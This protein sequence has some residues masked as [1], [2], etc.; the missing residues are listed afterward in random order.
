MS[1]LSERIARLS[2]EKRAVLEKRLQGSRE[3]APQA[4]VEPIAIVGLACRFPGAEDPDGFWQLLRGRGDAIREVPAD[5]WDAEALY[6]SNPDAPN[7]VT[8]RWGGFLD[9]VAD[10]DAYFFGI[11]PREAARMDPQ[12]RL[13]LEAAWEAFEDAGQTVDQLAGSQTGVF[14]GLHSHSSDYF[15]LQFDPAAGLDAFS[16]PGAA[17]NIAS[18]RLSYFFDLQGPNLVV[19]TACSSSLVAV[20]LACQSLRA[21]ECSMALAAGVNL[22]LTPYWTLP[23]ARMRMLAADGRCKT[24][25]AKADGMVRSEGCGAVV[26]K[27]VSDAVAHGDRIL[28]VI[29]GSAV[30]Q[31]GRTNGITAPNGVS[32]R[33]LLRQA[34]RNAGVRADAIS[35]VE[36][37][38]TGTAL[39]DPIEVEALAEVVGAS[40][41]DGSRC[42]L[43]AAKTNIGH[44]EGAAGIAG[45]IKIVLSLQHDAIPPLVHFS[46]LNPH[47][48]LA[49]TALEIPTALQAWTRG[50]A[51]RLA[52]VSS[53][54]WSGTNAHV[55][56]EEAPA[57]AARTD[58]A[59]V[60]R[61]FVLPLS[62]RHPDALKTLAARYRDLLAASDPA[63]VSLED[64]C[65]TA[66]L[67]RSHHEH[68]VALVA[69]SRRSMADALNAFVAG[70]P[71]RGTSSGRQSPG[72][73]PGVVFV[74][75]GQGPQWYAMGRELLE[76]E[77]VFAE[78]V[79][80][81]DEIVRKIAGWSPRAELLA[82]EA[83]SRVDQTEIA[84]PLLFTLQVAL[85]ALWRSWGVAP[86]AAIGHS[87]GEIA[88]AHLAGALTLEEAARVAVQRGQ[89]MQQ[90][91]G[92]GRMAVVEMPSRD[93]ERA[94]APFA[95]RVWIAAVNSAA[96]TVVSGEPAAIEELT[97]QLKSRE[98]LVR[99]MPVGYAFHSGQMEPC[100]RAVESALDGLRP[101][102]PRIPV[103][104]TVTGA[105]YSGAFDAAYWRRNVR[106]PV[107]FG[108]AL[109]AAIADDS[110]GE[111]KVFL[112][113]GPHP[114]L[115]EAIEHAIDGAPHRVVHSLRR[116]APERAS[117]LAALGGLYAAGCAVNWK[118][119][120]GASARCV[121]LPAYPW[122]RERYWIPSQTS[123]LLN[124][125]PR[126]ADADSGAAANRSP[127]DAL[128]EIGWV[129]APLPSSSDASTV[130]G[131]WLV[132][133]DDTGLGERLASALE[134]RGAT[135]TLVRRPGDVAR[136][137]ARVA[138]AA[139]LR[140]IVHLWS[141]DAAA[142]GI[143]PESVDA[144][145]KRICGSV[146]DLVKAMSAS[147][148][149]A[150]PVWLVTRGAQR[151]A[152]ADLS[153]AVSQAPLWGMARSV[154]IELSDVRFVRVDLDPAGSPADVDALIAELSVGPTADDQ[155]AYRGAIRHGAR[156]MRIQTSGGLGAGLTPAQSD[157]VY[158]ITGGLG[159]LGLHVANRLVARGA[160]RIV[161]AGRSGRAASSSAVDALRAAGADVV[162]A[163]ADVAVR[164]DVERLLQT[165][166]SLG[167]LRGIVHA[168]GV[169]DDGVVVQ[170]EWDRFARVMAPK[171]AGAWNLHA[172]T[173]DLSLDFFV[174]FS[175]A[176][177]V[178]GS[179][180]QANY[181]AAN[182]F[183]DALAHE[184]RRCGLA[185]L[186]VNWGAWAAGGMATNLEARDRQRWVEQGLAPIE[187]EQALD[188]L[189]ALVG[190]PR[191]QAAVMSM[192]WARYRTQFAGAL[193]AFLT[194]VATAPVA[195]DDAAPGRARGWLRGAV[196]QAAPRRRM[197]VLSAA[198]RE[199]VLAVLGLPSDFELDAHQGFRSIGLDS[200]LALEL[201]KR[202]QAAVDSALPATIAF[203]QPTVFDLSRY[204]AE[205]VLSLDDAREAVAAG[206]A[207]SAAI[208]VDALTDEMAEALLNAEL[209]ALR[210][211][212]GKR[213]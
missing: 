23:L 11:S 110:T 158:L 79:R 151:V 198:L 147:R 131:R 60:D 62:A 92:R 91:T 161:L 38:G 70:D 44:L 199:Q 188:A 41:P 152:A 154:A 156:L 178:L 135:A 67:R 203:D 56:V 18:G 210:G 117:M 202:L 144:D 118:P 138:G 184:R 212:L 25:D 150:P 36:T 3:A 26:L 68:R 6:D 73:A 101:S 66:A 139:P 22:M 10:F 146:L 201:R 55:I 194:L 4:G 187:P 54:G 27:R 172:L 30:N 16:G 87:V 167:S 58:T 29:R 109:A 1:D 120:H 123:G 49:G 206:A 94:I 86:S 121:R 99:P 191:A 114:V 186:S 20:H 124:V 173:S 168:A 53:F 21:A 113:I 208:D 159:A 148:A 204:L 65:Y 197:T 90:A 182:A 160:R 128:Y 125:A 24:F 196:E 116:N 106:Q 61:A 179:A 72:R 35:H 181:A 192:D 14:V 189:E 157:A 77:P 15:W 100:A 46:Q 98:V 175:S 162:I 149:G 103:F 155:V 52:G 81:C 12:Q 97:A 163:R 50:D 176:S 28:A 140:G 93:V 45:L 207:A 108:A 34:L 185:A 153:V 169:L 112:E 130:D 205:H 17:H 129:P 213:S 200:L 95:E 51:P 8:S 137:Y 43:G 190:S 59:P 96:S 83:A 166:A 64:V 75:S 47:I 141:L 132:L 39:G 165:A 19:D 107:L 40:R 80:Q 127:S 119:L 180:G 69:A 164:A 171:I 193:P 134:R 2:P 195:R 74:F 33:A 82:D 142:N 177:A 85:A 84:Q 63:D 89:A 104:S 211:D 145:Q 32:Q 122:Q 111:R 71:V 13:L 88:A 115:S 76:Q 78:A 57:P 48:S 105:R 31:D 170:Q 143:T 37:H 209:S 136:E 126:S 5:R 42:W 102:S 183:M 174:L 7:K 9:R 133:A